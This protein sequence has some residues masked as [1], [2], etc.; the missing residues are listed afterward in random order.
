MFARVSS[1]SGRPSPLTLGKTS[2]LVKV[3][4]YWHFWNAIRQT[5]GK[6]E[7]GEYTGEGAELDRPISRL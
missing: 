1:G 3:D 4:R 5:V 6:P 7:L 2:F